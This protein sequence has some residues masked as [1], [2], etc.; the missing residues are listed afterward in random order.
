MTYQNPTSH[1]GSDAGTALLDAAPSGGSTGS[2][3]SDSGASRGRAASANAFLRNLPSG[4]GRR[5]ISKNDLMQI[6]TQLSI[7]TR[8]GMDLSDAVYQIARQS[9]SPKI[10]GVMERVH[11]ELQEGR[12][13]SA[14]LAAQS[15][16]FGGAYVASVAAGEASGTLVDVLV[17]LKDLLRNEV[18]MQTTIRGVL[19]YPAI[20]LFVALGVLGAMLFFVLPQFDKVFRTLEVP[21]P[22]ITQFLLDVGHY[23]RENV[24]LVALGVAGIAF[25]IFKLWSSNGFRRFRDR[26]VLQ[27]AWIRTGT[28]SLFTG[29]VFRMIGSMLQSG[30][31]LL[32]AIRLCRSSIDNLMFHEMFAEMEAEILAGQG[33]SGALAASGC[34]P[35]GAA[36]MIATAERSG[37]LGSVME[38]VGEFYEDEGE[39]RIRSQMRLLEPAIIVV[40]G[41]LVAFV[42]A[43][44]MLP[45]FDLSSTTHY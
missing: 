14:A 34:V 26:A 37:D 23:V 15:D 40:M 24:W 11:Y 4:S 20:L 41:G 39:R 12:S 36:E 31:P 25:G 7:M 33:I 8:S 42:V 9:K 1:D 10:E 16:V 18:R 27:T 13:F 22:A 2:A 21:A 35:T 3:S 29:R 45:L 38:M 5:R 43:A 19:M 44:V 6:T 17:R 28:Q 32:E 30:V